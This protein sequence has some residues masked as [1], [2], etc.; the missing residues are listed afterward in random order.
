MFGTRLADQPLAA[1]DL[2]VSMASLFMLCVLFASRST[3]IVGKAAHVTSLNTVLRPS[4]TFS[5]SSFVGE[6]TS[7]VFLPAVTAI[8]SL[9]APFFPPEDV[10]GFPGPTP[11]KRSKII[12]SLYLIF[13]TFHKPE[14]NQN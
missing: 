5:A 3:L 11:S 4:Q 8:A 6:T 7:F 10:V 2:L 13:L 12:Y 9:N 1:S 14:M